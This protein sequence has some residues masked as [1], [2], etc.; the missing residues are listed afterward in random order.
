MGG[1]VGVLG[2]WVG[3]KGVG[4]VQT[5]RNF[6]DPTFCRRVACAPKARSHSAF[7]G[8]MWRLVAAAV[9]LLTLPSASSAL[10][11]QRAASRPGTLATPNRRRLPP[12]VAHATALPPPD[13]VLRLRGGDGA[14]MLAGVSRAYLGMPTLTR[15]WFTL[16]LLL[17]GL[18]Q[19]GIL[20][21]EAVALDAS[22]TVRGLQLWRPI[23][24]ASFMGGL[25]P[26]LLQ[27]VYYLI[28][29][30]RGL[31]TALGFG[32]FARV[33]A[34]CTALLC[35]VS[36]TLG[37]QFVSDGLIMC[38]TVL[39]CQQSPDQ[40]MNLYGL[41]LPCAY[42]PFAQLCMSYMFTQQIPWNDILGAVVVRPAGLLRPA[43]AC[44]GLLRPAAACC[45][46]PPCCPA[47]SRR[48]ACGVCVGIAALVSHHWRP[49]PPHADP[50]PHRPHRATHA[51]LAARARRATCTTASTITPSPIPPSESS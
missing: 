1:V 17:A 16:I 35:L 27:K 21:P 24:A 23:T 4:F 41:N 12:F 30:G 32:E 33:L 38:I 50:P 6:N 5:G 13:G 19:I 39:T 47:D 29:F 7:S 10:E 20:Q 2:G 31:E 28:Q 46:P 43:A 14:S 34:S 9:A 25:G 48:L 36:A 22:A 26:Q 45:A 37:F 8:G 18:T 44:C 15:S 51:A 11:Q 40:V 49:R 3:G 42:F